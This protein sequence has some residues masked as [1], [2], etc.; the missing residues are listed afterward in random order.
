MVRKSKQK[1]KIERAN[2]HLVDSEPGNRSNQRWPGGRGVL[3]K[4]L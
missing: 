1:R 3:L 4:T 2:I